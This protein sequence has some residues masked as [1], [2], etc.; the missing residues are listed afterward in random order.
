MFDAL[1]VPVI[2]APMA[3]GAST[4]RLVAE[5]GN[6][7]G[8]GFLAAGYL[9]V[10]ALA[11]EIRRTGDLT[12]RPF[13][14]NLF[15]PGTRTTTDLTGYQERVRAQARPFGVEPGEPRWDDDNYG[16]KLE[17]VL[18]QRVPVVSFTFGLPDAD[19]VRRL[20]AAGAKIVVTVTTP[21]EARQA[22]QVGADALCVQGADAGAHRGTFSDD[23]IS[24]GGGELYGTLAAIRLVAASVDLPLIATGGLVHGADVAAVLTA[25][26]VAAQLGTAFLGCPEAGTKPAHREALLEGARRTALTRAFSGR[27]AR[28]LVNRFLIENSPYA[29]AAYPNVHHLTKPVRATGDVEVMSLWAGTT[30]PLATAEPAADVV[31]RLDQEA[32]DAI[33]SVAARF[34]RD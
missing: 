19:D 11:D 3:G 15:V 4:P 28:G 12:D 1:T 17:L 20:H 23:G 9:T 16:A 7:G 25:G 18:A 22:Q 32:R 6:A 30:Y 8:F 21:S 10:E 29:P 27:P 34:A 5:V 14:V 2:A 33:K 26:A 24:P 31:R 13:G